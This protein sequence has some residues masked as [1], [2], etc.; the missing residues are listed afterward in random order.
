M[1]NNSDDIKTHFKYIDEKLNDL[2]SDVSEIKDSVLE[3]KQQGS[4]HNKILEINTEQLKEHILR[5]NLLE[6]RVEQ[7]AL[8][9]RTEL[10]P[11]E[12]HVKFVNKLM[13]FS[14]SAIK[15]IGVII[16]VVVGILAIYKFIN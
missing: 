16:S 6:V 12:D 14:V 2:K 5:T 7:T 9:F 3:L 10:Q 15:T 13:V 1:S 8:A 11:V 4:I